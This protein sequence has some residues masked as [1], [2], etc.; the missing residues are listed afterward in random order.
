MK[1][2]MWTYG[3]LAKELDFSGCE[4][5][6][7]DA[8]G[9][10]TKI[11]RSMISHCWETGKGWPDMIAFETQGH[12]DNK[13]RMAKAINTPPWHSWH[14]LGILGFPL[15]SSGPEVPPGF[16]WSTAAIS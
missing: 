11:L 6:V 13:E 16:S 2:N 3:K 12:C 8:E 14:P 9:D 5:L 15:A 1:T 4:L 7:I 10:D